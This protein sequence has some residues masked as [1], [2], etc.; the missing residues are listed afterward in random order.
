[1]GLTFW[2]VGLTSGWVGR[3]TLVLNLWKLPFHNKF[4]TFLLNFLTTKLELYF[5]FVCEL[6]RTRLYSAKMNYLVCLRPSGLA[7]HSLS[8][9]TMYFICVGS[10]LAS[11]A[12]LAS[13]TQMSA[14]VHMTSTKG[15]IVLCFV[16]SIIF[17]S[18]KLHLNKVTWIRNFV[19]L[20]M[21]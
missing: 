1:M 5:L 21:S 3:I 6:F 16:F 19:L 7:T 17:I 8:L 14:K 2:L 15:M 12:K 13:L 4:I 18:I 20:N 10:Y 9:S 11:R